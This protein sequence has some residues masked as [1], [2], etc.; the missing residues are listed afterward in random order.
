MH[1]CFQKIHT[2]RAKNVPKR[3]EYRLV[4]SK[5]L[6]E[7]TQLHDHHIPPVCLLCVCCVSGRQR[8]AADSLLKPDLIVWKS[9]R[10][11]TREKIVELESTQHEHHRKDVRCHARTTGPTRR[12]EPCYRMAAQPASKGDR[13][14]RVEI[15]ISAADAPPRC[16]S[17]HAA[18]WLRV[19]VG[20]RTS[21]CSKDIRCGREV[22]PAQ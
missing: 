4:S 11:G 22:L 2:V 3:N 8:N 13:C 18:R 10:D 21:T 17:R 16:L 20:G 9:C 12:R 5:C 1:T 6:P 15:G 14:E 7:R 19:G